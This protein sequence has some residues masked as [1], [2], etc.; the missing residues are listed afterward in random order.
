M[1]TS[2]AYI[3]TIDTPLS[4]E[5]AKTCSD[6]CDKVGL[7]WEYFKGFSNQSIVDAWASA[8]VEVP[9]IKEM[10]GRYKEPNNVQCCTAGHAAIWKMI[11]EGNE[12]AIILEHDAIMLQPFDLDIEDDMIVVLG[13]K[14][15]DINRY[16]HLKAGKSTRVVG[17]NGHEGAHAYAMTP[18]TAKTLIQE[19]AERGILGN[20]DNAYFI[21]GQRNTQVRLGI[22]DPTP[23]IGW[24]RQSTLWSESADRNYEFIDSFQQNYK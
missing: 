13:Y 19:I 3:L 14:L 8:K 5:Y 17:I 21:R 12:A 10:Y 2:K 4:L 11:A 6:S 1:K 15:T 16:D 23:A 20:V 9:Y 7:N 22:A 24:L 18:N